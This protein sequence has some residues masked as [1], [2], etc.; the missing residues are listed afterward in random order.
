MQTQYIVS[1]ECISAIFHR[2]SLELGDFEGLLY[3]TRHVV[4]SSKLKDDG[5]YEKKIVTTVY[6]VFILNVPKI[7]LGSSLLIKT[8][9]ECPQGMQIIG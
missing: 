3:G 8:F 4:N 9:S 1:S 7:I 5:T 6:N 2:L